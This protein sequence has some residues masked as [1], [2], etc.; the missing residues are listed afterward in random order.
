M[1]ES[2]NCVL[3]VDTALKVSYNQRSV[4]S[5][6]P[7]RSFAEPTKTTTRTITATVTNGHQFDISALIVRDGIPLGDA[8][9]NIKV[10]L[11]KPDG[12]AQAKDGEEVPI[13][14][15]ADVQDAKVRWSK[16][17]KGQ[18]GEKDG[19]YEWVCGTVVSGKEVKFEAEWDIKSPAN[20]RWEE[21][22]KVDPSE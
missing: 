5:Q 12:L 17:E 22:Q 1:N 11:R 16:V 9:T 6:E 4:T 21:T 3:G 13:D 15:G 18:G 14:L 7:P 10:M 19:M 8:D 2:F 20:L